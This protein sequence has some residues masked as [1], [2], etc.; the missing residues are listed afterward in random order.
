MSPEGVLIMFVGSI[1]MDSD[2]LSSPTLRLTT[3]LLPFRNSGVMPGLA[4]RTPLIN[5]FT[6]IVP[7]KL[8]RFLFITKWTSPFS[9]SMMVFLAASLDLMPAVDLFKHMGQLVLAADPPAAHTHDPTVLRSLMT[10]FGLEHS[11][12]VVAS[13]D[14]VQVLQLGSQTKILKS[15]MLESFVEPESCDGATNI[16]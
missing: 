8:A 11:V 13:N 9:L 4:E 5:E 15:S 3:L 6:P 7:V 16:F 14:L 12:H 10:K 2:S 1:W